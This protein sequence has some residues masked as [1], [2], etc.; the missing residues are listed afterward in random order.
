M[1][2]VVIVELMAKNS[3]AQISTNIWNISMS[4]TN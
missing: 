2:E 4:V 1:T 3:Q